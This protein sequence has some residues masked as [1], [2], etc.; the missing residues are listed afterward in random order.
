MKPLFYTKVIVALILLQLLCVQSNGAEFKQKEEGKIKPSFVSLN[1]RM[2]TVGITG[3]SIEGVYAFQIAPKTDIGMTLGRTL[4]VNSNLFGVT[5]RYSVLNRINTPF[6]EIRSI[7]ERLDEGGFEL[8]TEYDPDEPFR[9]GDIGEVYS[10]TEQELWRGTGIVFLGFNQ[11][12]KKSRI[13]I[14]VKYGISIPFFESEMM[15]KQEYYNNTGISK[16][17][18]VGFSYSFNNTN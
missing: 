9:W 17:F 5:Y 11:S 7:I 10:P 3:L 14:E 13:S 2:N 18:S 6:F 12:I 1:T 4:H 15:K 8:R 16:H